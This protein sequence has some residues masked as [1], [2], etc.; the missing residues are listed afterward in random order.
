[1]AGLVESHSQDLTGLG[2]V[3]LP[4]DLGVQS[5]LSSGLLFCIESS[6][7]YILFLALSCSLKLSVLPLILAHFSSFPV[8]NQ[9]QGSCTS[10]LA[11]LWG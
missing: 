5:F 1:M 9:L 4:S 10:P 11:L 6:W 2:K 8:G 7:G 3:A